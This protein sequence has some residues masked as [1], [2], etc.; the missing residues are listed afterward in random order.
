M[1]VAS[2]AGVAVARA[3]RAL[4]TGAGGEVSPSA[5][6]TMPCRHGHGYACGWTIATYAASVLAVVVVVAK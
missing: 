2:V 4:G 3:A 6:N 1:A 5:S